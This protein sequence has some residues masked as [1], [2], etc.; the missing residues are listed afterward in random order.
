MNLSKFAFLVMTSMYFAILALFILKVDS[1]NELIAIAFF[2][3]MLFFW[4]MYRIFVKF[5]K[6]VYKEE[7][8]SLQKQINDLKKQ[9]NS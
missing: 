7:F 3:S 6:S 2:A 5:T 4:W 9:L 8:E 1:T